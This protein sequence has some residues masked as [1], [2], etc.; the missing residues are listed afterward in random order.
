MESDNRFRAKLDDRTRR[1]LVEDVA[2][3]MD[4][5][6]AAEKYGVQPPSGWNLVIREAFRVA[7]RDLGLPGMRA[8]EFLRHRSGGRAT[9]GS[10][11]SYGGRPADQDV[12][13]GGATSLAEAALQAAAALQLLADAARPGPST[14]SD[15][16][17][18]DEPQPFGRMVKEKQIN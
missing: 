8:D 16:T 17:P 18:A 11:P 13:A 7:M 4:L 6:R 5:N 1:A 2:A 12:G 14:P 10:V 9:G 3:G 15:N